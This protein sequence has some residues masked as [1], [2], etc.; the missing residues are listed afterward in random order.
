METRAHYV[1]VG[2]FVLTVL[3]LLVIAVLWLARVQ[4]NQQSVFYD[5]YFVGSVTGLSQG[6]PVRYNGVPVGRVEQIQLDP[7]DPQRVR[8]TIEVNANTVIKSDAVASLEMQGLTGGAF[9]EITGGSRDAPPL[10]R[11]EGQRYPVIASRPSGLQQVVTSAPE[12]LA[13]LVVLADRLNQILDERNQQAIAETLD[14]LRRATAAVAGRSA[15]IKGALD[16]GAAA[17][18]DLRATIAKTGATMDQI[19]ALIGH[20]GSVG[21]ALK[22][23]EETSRRA[24]DA[25]GH[26]DAL[27]QE[28]RQPLRDFSERGL[29]QMQQLL[30]DIRTLVAEMTRVTET[31]RRDPTRFLYGQDRGG[32][33]PR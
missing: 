12:A 19:N 6:S 27:I 16:D 5:I 32:Y 23:L 33:Q 22:S 31:L 13:R 14:N 8:V 11:H 28:N 3:A 4:F 17:V 30:G 24:S 18:R 20:G 15:E 1:V 29:D 7:Q 21:A 25:V 10:E 2:G 9:I 26:L